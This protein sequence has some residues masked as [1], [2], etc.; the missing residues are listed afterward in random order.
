MNPPRQSGRFPLYQVKATH[1]SA[2]RAEVR[3]PGLEVLPWEIPD[4]VMDPDLM[5]DMSGESDRLRLELLYL[6]ERLAAATAVRWGDAVATVLRS[7]V[8]DPTAVLDLGL[9]DPLAAP[10]DPDHARPA[11]A[12]RADGR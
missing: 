11:P 6:P 9:L 8:A 1:Q 3:L 7:G 10:A 5:L 2:W 4:R 12:A